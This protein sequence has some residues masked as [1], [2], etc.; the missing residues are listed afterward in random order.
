M[1]GPLCMGRGR[2]FKSTGWSSSLIR[3]IRYH[4]TQNTKNLG[5][6]VSAK[7]DGETPPAPETE[8]GAQSTAGKKTAPK[9]ET[10]G[11]SG[12]EPTRYGDWERKGR[13]I[14]F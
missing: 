2:G 6:S 12:P 5:Q 11:P 10:G 1:R 7:D 9:R 4:M 8:T 3:G 14:D 13:C